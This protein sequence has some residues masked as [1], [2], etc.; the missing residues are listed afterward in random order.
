MGYMDPSGAFMVPGERLILASQLL[1]SYLVRSPFAEAGSLH[2]GGRAG[3][4]HQARYERYASPDTHHSRALLHESPIRHLG[5]SGTIEAPV[6]SLIS[7]I[8]ILSFLGSATYPPSSGPSFLLTSTLLLR[9]R[10]GILLTLLHLLLVEQ[11]TFPMGL[12]LP[13]CP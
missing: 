3:V 7:F 4:L 9:D 1:P 5:R 2:S 13:R 6:A 10:H 12:S 8:F 11:K